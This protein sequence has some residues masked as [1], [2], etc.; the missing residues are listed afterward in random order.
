MLTPVPPA[1]RPRM[2]GKAL[3][4]KHPSQLGGRGSWAR[5]ASPS[6]RRRLNVSASEIGSPIGAGG[7]LFPPRNRLSVRNAKARSS[8][9]CAP[10]VCPKTISRGFAK[11]TIHACKGLCCGAAT[12][13]RTRNSLIRRT[14]FRHSR[15]VIGEAPS[16]RAQRRDE[17]CQLRQKKL[18]PILPG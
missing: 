5:Y 12:R 6:R 10:A 7:A 2:C 11:L 4:T 3:Q 15:H 18:P 9:S 8:S 1:N 16:D 13:C 14:F 17:L